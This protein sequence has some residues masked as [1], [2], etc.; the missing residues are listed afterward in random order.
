MDLVNPCAKFA[1]FIG[2]VPWFTAKSIQADIVK[3]ARLSV[4][5]DAH[6]GTVTD[7]PLESFVEN[8]AILIDTASERVPLWKWLVLTV[9]LVTPMPGLAGSCPQPSAV[10]D[11]KPQFTQLAPE[12]QLTGLTFW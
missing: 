4:P 10:P 2:S 7:A 12:V 5:L 3:P 11:S 9:M 8:D 6:S 1:A